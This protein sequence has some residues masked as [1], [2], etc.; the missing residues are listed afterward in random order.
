MLPARPTLQ[1]IERFHHL[2]GARGGWMSA[3]GIPLLNPLE[4]VRCH[5]LDRSRNA[6]AIVACGGVCAESAG[7]IMHVV[8]IRV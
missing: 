6:E 3:S 1:E 8:E 5:D 4:A 2:I 7:K